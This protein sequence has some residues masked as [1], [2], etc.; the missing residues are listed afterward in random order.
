MIVKI[1]L[2]GTNHC[3]K[4]CTTSIPREERY[5]KHWLTSEHYIN[6]YIGEMGWWEMGGCFR[7]IFSRRVATESSFYMRVVTDAMRTCRASTRDW[8]VVSLVDSF[9]DILSKEVTRVSYWA[10][11]L[12][13]LLPVTAKRGSREAHPDLRDSTLHRVLNSGRWRPRWVWM[14]VV[15]AVQY[16][17]SLR[18]LWSGTVPGNPAWNRR[19]S[20]CID[21]APL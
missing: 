1:S 2:T 13:R 8:S 19:A 6:A 10:S 5:V 18:E 17:D 12:S 20:V 3:T 11:V 9:V 16:T 21:V 4:Y 15:M 7:V 14:V